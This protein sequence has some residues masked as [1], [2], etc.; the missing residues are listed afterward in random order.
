MT[1]STKPKS[2]GRPKGAKTQPRP[3]AQT[4]P[5]RCPVC[6]STERKP[7]TQ[8]RTQEY[9]GIDADGQAYTHILR[10]WTACAECGQARIDRTYENREKKP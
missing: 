6:D 3:V 10:R 5:S 7:Y 8:T 2:P 4:Q 1:K 9:P